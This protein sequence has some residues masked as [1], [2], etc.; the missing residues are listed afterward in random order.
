MTT[1]SKQSKAFVDKLS[2]DYPEFKFVEGKQDHWS[3][4]TKTIIYC[5]GRDL[6]E[7][8]YSLLHELAHAL[9]KHSDYQSDFELL[10]LESEAWELAARIAPTYGV[11]VSED[12]IQNCLDTYRDW[13]HRRSTCPSCSVH[14]FQKDA[15]TY[16]CFNCQAEWS[17]TTRHFVRAY[18][19]TAAKTKKL[20]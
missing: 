19:K 15:Q 18:R 2:A 1:S 4:G 20:A 17:V 8:K 6:A 3:P 13:L 11:N 9:L 16:K 10:R 12:H 7:T 5:P 14:V